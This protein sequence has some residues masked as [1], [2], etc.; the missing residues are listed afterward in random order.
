MKNILKIFRYLV[1]AVV[2]V[3]LVSIGIDAADNYDNISESIVGRMVFGESEGPCSREMVFVPNDAGGFCIDKYEASPGKECPARF[4]ASQLDTR[5]NLDFNECQPVSVLGAQPWRFIS[6]TQA[7]TACAKAGKRLPSNE[8]WYQ[9]SLGTPDP[10]GDWQVDACQVDH[11][12]T[13]QPGESGSAKNCVSSYGAYDMI[14]N[15]WEWV[16]G[17]ITDGQFEGEDMPNAGYVTSVSSD[18]NII[19]TSNK[20]DPNFNEDYL[21]IKKSGLRGIA[22]GGYWGNGAEAGVY[23][24]Y[25]VSP[26]SFAGDGVG[27]RCVK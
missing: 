2:A 5:D 19:S 26:T 6:Q 17:E 18:G 7:M 23:A 27:F 15:V 25:L 4:I 14:G 21:W 10:D 3:V 22:R 12:W 9:A 16:K 20:K 13:K 8:E 24:M 11:N 1:V